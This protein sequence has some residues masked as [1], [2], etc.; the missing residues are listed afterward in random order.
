MV[1]QKGFYGKQEKQTLTSLRSKSPQ[2]HQK[3]LETTIIEQQRSLL[4]FVRLTNVF[5]KE[6]EANMWRFI[7]RFLLQQR[8]RDRFIDNVN[9]KKQNRFTQCSE[10]IFAISLDW[11]GVALK[12]LEVMFAKRCP[13][14]TANPF[15]KWYD[16]G[17]SLDDLPDAFKG[18]PPDKRACIVALWSESFGKWLFAKSY[19]CLFGIGSVRVSF[20]RP[21]ALVTAVA[22]KLGICMCATYFDDLITLE[23]FNFRAS[24]RPFFFVD[25]LSVGCPTNASKIVPVRTAPCM[26]RHCAQLGDTQKR[27]DKQSNISSILKDPHLMKTMSKPWNIWPFWSSVAPPRAFFFRQNLSSSLSHLLGCVSYWGSSHPPWLGAFHKWCFHTNRIMAVEAFAVV[28]AIWQHR[29]ILTRKDVIFLQTSELPPVSWSK[30]IPDSLSSEPW[31]CAFNCFWSATTSRCR[32]SWQTPIHTLRMASAGMTKQ[33]LG[34]FNKIG[35]TRIPTHSFHNV[36]CLV[37]NNFPK[38]AG[39]WPVRFSWKCVQSILS[40]LNFCCVFPSNCTDLVWTV[41]FCHDMKRNHQYITRSLWVLVFPSPCTWCEFLVDTQHASCQFDSFLS[42]VSSLIFL[43][44]WLAFHP[45]R[46]NRKTSTCC[47]LFHVLVMRLTRRRLGKSLQNVIVE[48]MS[49]LCVKRSTQD[50]SIETHACWQ[51]WSEALHSSVN[52]ALDFDVSPLDNSSVSRHLATH[53]FRH[54]EN[55]FCHVF[56]VGVQGTIR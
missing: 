7:L 43:D 1:F 38:F 20:N 12:C 28:T 34:F 45:M 41:F 21:P 23:S 4:G 22:K 27:L 14:C 37:V 17:C 13:E 47:F 44:L 29:D 5:N 30:V 36:S 24:V 18:C 56:C 8:L 46:K 55:L 16:P 39:K 10:T 6:F 51:F 50:Q 53:L 49:T 40:N 35:I 15:P 33:T 11:L 32:S 48:L 3:I 26:A 25:S 9:T 31:Q 2:H 52:C 42:D 19:S 54:H